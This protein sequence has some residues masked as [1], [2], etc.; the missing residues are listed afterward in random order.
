MKTFLIILTDLVLVGLFTIY[1]RVGAG[2]HWIG[3]LGWV[4][5]GFMVVVAYEYFFRN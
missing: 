3:L 4:I 5:V 2:W 1:Y